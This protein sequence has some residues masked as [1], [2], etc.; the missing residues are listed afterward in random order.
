MKNI[1]LHVLLAKTD[2]LSKTWTTLLENYISFFSSKQGAFR[3]EL[4][5]YEPKTGQLDKPEERGNTIVIT[6]VDE[7]LQY[8]EENT[9]DYIDALMSQEATNASGTVKADLYVDGKSLGQY[10]ALE[11]L[12]LKTLI[13][14]RTFKDMYENIPVHTENEIWN[15]TT[16][17]Q[18]R[19]RSIK[20]GVLQSS[21]VRTSEKESYIL[22]D[23]NIKE[24][25]AGNYQPQ[26][27][28]KTTIIELGNATR[29]KFTGEWSHRQRAE[30]LGRRSKLLVALTEAL[31][32]AN[33]AETV[34]SEMTATKLFAYLHRGHIQSSGTAL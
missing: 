10:S 31:K 34:A 6:T 14:S 20:E 1:K 11:L 23:P 21:V 3:G 22:P 5:T 27:G 4:K 25:K 2:M 12:R 16:F 28:T 9:A 15:P 19:G 17:E 33:E 8:L 24:G 13:E 32:V 26:L 30:V 29:Q 18:Y 7:K